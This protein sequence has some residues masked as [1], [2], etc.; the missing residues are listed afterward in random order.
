MAPTIIS[1]FISDNN[2]THRSIE[3][4]IEYGKKLIN[5][6]IHKIIFI[7]KEIY[8]K[9]LSEL[10]KVDEVSEVD[11]VDEVD[12][13]SEVDEVLSFNE[14]TTFI[15]IKK[16]DIYLYEYYDQITNFDPITNNPN[17][18]TI[19]Y[20]FIQCYKTEFM[21]MG[22]ELNPYDSSQFIWIDFGIYHMIGNDELLNQLVLNL[23]TSYDYNLI[24]IAGGIYFPP[25][26]EDVYKKVCWCF[27]GSIFGG[28][29]DKLVHFANLMKQKCIDTII[30]KNTITW[31]V[32]IWYL[33]Y[34]EFPELFSIYISNHNP[35][36][37]QEY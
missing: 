24:R 35:T 27:L 16:K 33:I 11:E 22:I 32:N 12:E 6:P 26:E 36:M 13:V 21:R 18:D 19:D 7:E 17:K 5:V 2:I 4:Y 37:I 15:F 9:F 23:N 31:E 34:K 20:M 28:E 14:Y 30:N 8:K 29:N 10:S 1:G 3:Q 25:S